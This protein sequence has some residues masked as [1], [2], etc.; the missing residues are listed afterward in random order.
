MRTIIIFILGFLVGRWYALRNLRTNEGSLS[1]AEKEYTSSINERRHREAEEKKQKVL[2]LAQ[3]KDF[4]TND[5]VQ[6]S[7][8]VS[9]TTATRYLDEL[10][11]EGKLEQ[12]GHDGRF[13]KYKLK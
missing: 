2:E 11:K 4:I 3:G 10:E 5:D 9:D 7:L 1:D 13:V 6:A 12:I 8:N